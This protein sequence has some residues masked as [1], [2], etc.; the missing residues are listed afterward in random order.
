MSVE[1]KEFGNA[2]FV[3]DKGLKKDPNLKSLV[4]FTRALNKSAA[5]V[6][7]AGKLAEHRPAN[8]E[9]Y[10]KAKIWEH[11]EGLPRIESGIFSS[12][13]FDTVAVWDAS[14]GEAAAAPSE[15]EP[16][17]NTEDFRQENPPSA[18]RMSPVKD[19]DLRYRAYCLVMFGPVDEVSASQ[20]GQMIDVCND[21]YDAINPL[22]EQ[23]EAIT[24]EP[25]VLS[26]PREKQSECLTWVRRNAR[27]DAKWP[28]YKNLFT[29][30]LDTAQDTRT[31]TENGNDETKPPVPGKAGLPAVCPGKAAQ[32]N[33]EL[34]EAFAQNASNEVAK[35][36]VRPELNAREIEIAHALND[37]ISGRTTIMDE[38]EAAGVIACTGHL[39]PY[40]IALL[41]ADITI[42]ELHLAPD[43]SDEEIHD[44]ATTTLDAW[45][46]DLNIRQQVMLDAIVEYRKPAPAPVCTVQSCRNEEVEKINAPAITALTYRQQL[47][48]A[49]LQG[50]CANPA[51]CNTSEDIPKIAD[52]L[53]TG[54]SQMLDGDDE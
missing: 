47:T 50:L 11:R 13:F 1:L 22:R 14:A 28:D 40:V 25:R 8:I 16:K 18:E 49:A 21:D 53:A 29:R 52:W 51:Y 35:E 26:L 43:F 2:F 19:L 34:E 42:T 20:R 27:Q 38:G 39:I 12:D 31:E 46:D 24:K 33:R 54:L 3:K 36:E 17:D 32:L 6:I 44:V 5:E 37:L 9:D 15:T 41:I 7:A 10:F 30:W 4:I 48:I 45:S 23:A